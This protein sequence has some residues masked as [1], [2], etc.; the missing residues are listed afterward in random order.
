MAILE[1]DPV[2]ILHTL[3]D[4]CHRH[5]L[6]PLAQTLLEQ[7]L[8]EVTLLGI[9]QNFLIGVSSLAEHKD[10]RRDSVGGAEKDVH[11]GERTDRIDLTKVTDDIFSESLEQL[12]RLQKL[13][14]QQL[15]KVG[16]VLA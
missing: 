6:L 2:T 13:D 11:R 4:E 12:L 16:H 8:I 1:E 10:Y 3:L 7:L 15:L 5:F 9:V 14:K